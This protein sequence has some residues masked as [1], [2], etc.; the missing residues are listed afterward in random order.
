[1]TGA[2]DT[3]SWPATIARNTRWDIDESTNEQD[4]ELGLL[5]TYGVLVVPAP[6]H[7][8]GG[9]LVTLSA[10]DSDDEQYL[11]GP[12]GPIFDSRDEAM[13]EAVRIMDWLAERPGETNLM[14]AWTQMQ[15]MNTEAEM[16]PDGRPGRLH[17]QW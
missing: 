12:E 17:Y 4:D 1:M 3:R 13:Q 14:E 16:W 9:W 6:P 2:L 15:Q 7:R 11:A 10:W 8:E 5:G